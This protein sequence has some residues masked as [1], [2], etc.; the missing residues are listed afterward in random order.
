MK[1]ASCLKNRTPLVE[2]FSLRQVKPLLKANIL[3]SYPVHIESHASL[4]S[5]RAMSTDSLD[6]MMNEDIS[7][8]WLTSS[9]QKHAG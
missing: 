7:L 3:D 4:N 5:R 2:V 1:N 6:G 9:S 8:C